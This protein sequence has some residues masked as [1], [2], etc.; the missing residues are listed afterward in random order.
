[1][2]HP[3]RGRFGSRSRWGRPAWSPSR[4]TMVVPTWIE[5][6]FGVDPDGGSGALEIAILAVLLG[7][8]VM[9][10]SLARSEWRR[11]VTSS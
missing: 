11:A 9:T 2:M 4:I 3:V 7:S 6:V 1:M 10:C 5:Q 8:A